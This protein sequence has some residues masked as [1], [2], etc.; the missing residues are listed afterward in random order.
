M[1]ILSTHRMYV[2]H[3]RDPNVRDPAGTKEKQSESF[4]RKLSSGTSAGGWVDRF[5]EM[6]EKG[7]EC[8]KCCYCGVTDEIQELEAGCNLHCN[9]SWSVAQAIVDR[10]SH[11]HGHGHGH[12][13]GGG[14]GGGAVSTDKHSEEIKSAEW[15]FLDAID[16]DPKDAKVRTAYATFLWKEVGDVK[17]AEI[18][19][20]TAAELADKSGNPNLLAAAAYFFM[21][22][23]GGCGN[24]CAWDV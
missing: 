4:Y 21:C 10:A 24:D 1:S 23:D 9:C 13:H 15:F 14:H 12:G 6:S 5:R 17:R 16:K 20:T 19:F 18:E 3:R 22:P 7:P 2:V 8:K 11:S